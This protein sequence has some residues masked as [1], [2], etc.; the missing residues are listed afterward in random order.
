MASGFKRA[1]KVKDFGDTIPGHG[2]ITDRFDCHVRFLSF[3]HYLCCFLLSASV[4]N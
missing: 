1:F 3:Y 4:Y 2:G